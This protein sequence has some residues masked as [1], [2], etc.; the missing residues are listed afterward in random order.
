M[1]HSHAHHDLLG[2]PPPTLLPVPPDAAALRDGGADPV[3][4][5]AAFPTYSAGWA[6]LAER[7]L[8]SDAGT[9][10]AVQGYAYARV[11]YHRGLDALRRHGWKGF[12]PVPYAH[13]GNRGYLRSV[14]ALARAAGRI[15]EAPE[16]QRCLELL[17]DGDPAAVQALT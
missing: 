13:E 4:V 15:G 10:A 14:A 17:A 12:G 3:E 11:G 9:A 1:T 16:E 2:G 5:V 7:A 8:S 6:D